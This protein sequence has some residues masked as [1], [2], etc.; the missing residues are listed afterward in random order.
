LTYSNAGH[1]PLIVYKAATDEVVEKNVKG[2]AIGFLEGYKYKEGT[3]ALDSKDILVYYTDG[4]TE[5]ENNVK[6][7]FGIER[8]K[9]IIY[10]N[11]KESSERI[12]ET[13]LQEIKEFR[14]SHDQLDDIT[15]LVVKI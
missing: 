5:C 9:K 1:N 10:E 7:M 3:I 2:T 15:L 12:K 11:R 8:L 6:E 14:N 13:I 4:I